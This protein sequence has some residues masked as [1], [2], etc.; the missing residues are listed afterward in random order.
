MSL[1]LHAGPTGRHQ[2][3]GITSLPSVIDSSSCER[4]LTNFSHILC[5][6]GKLFGSNGL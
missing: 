6:M 3:A 2:F 1:L 5:H 4:S